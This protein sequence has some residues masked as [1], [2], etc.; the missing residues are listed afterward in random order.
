MTQALAD[1]AV[2][3]PDFA[4]FAAGRQQEPPALQELR[5]SAFARFTELG[6]PTAHTE[7]WRFTNVRPI[8]DTAWTRAAARW[9]IASPQTLPAGVTIR[10]LRGD[11]L[12]RLG[13]VARSESDPFAALNTAFFED[14]LVVEIAP[15]AVVREPIEIRFDTTGSEIPEVSHPRLLVLA[16]ERSQ[17]TL[18][19]TF[20][21]R[22]GR[23]YFTNAVTEIVVSDGALL[24][25]AK[26][27]R[28]DLDA[29][30]V[31]ALAVRV[32]RQAR[33]ASTDV[34]LGGALARTNLDVLLAEEGAECEL[35]GLF[36]AAGAQHLDTH[37]FIDHAKPHGTSRELYK[38]I[39]DGRARGVFHGTVLVRHGAQKTD[40]VQTNKNLLLSKEALVNS[41]PAL[42]ILADDVKCKHGSTTGQLDAT[43]LFY[44]RSR[45]LDEAEARALLVRAFASEVVGRIPA[46]PA[47]AAAE[48]ALDARLPSAPEAA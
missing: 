7:A 10:P 46:A 19:E 23:T 4:A 14:G 45:G 1:E 39:L 3:A 48:A 32:G 11:A 38:G 41:T 31:H 27:Q 26:V 34:A 21:G 18:V 6:F 42:E 16:G 2:F 13:S 9:P 15:G 47:R 22:G 36:V 17:A 28:E 20:S 33:F 40:A 8:V 29:R 25:Y 5:P 37:T 12:P 24:S 44:L 35:D 30:H 43:A